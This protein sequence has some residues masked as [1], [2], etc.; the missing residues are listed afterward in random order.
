MKDG[1]RFGPG[2]DQYLQPSN[3]RSDYFFSDPQSQPLSSSMDQ[4]QDYFNHHHHQ[5]DSTIQEK[6]LLDGKMRELALEE[7]IYQLGKKYLVKTSNEERFLGIDPKDKLK[8]IVD[9]MEMI[10]PKDLQRDVVGKYFK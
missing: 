6:L 9:E 5:H 1:W 4:H 2:M 8:E 3:K 7:V 10:M